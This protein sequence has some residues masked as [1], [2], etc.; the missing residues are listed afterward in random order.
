MYKLSACTLEIFKLWTQEKRKE[1]AAG[2]K[3][4]FIGPVPFVGT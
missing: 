1:G 3:K 2:P 4:K